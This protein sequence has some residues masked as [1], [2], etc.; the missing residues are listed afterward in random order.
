MSKLTG[1]TALVTGASRGIGRAIALR[2]ASEGARVGVHYASNEAAAKETVATIEAAGGTAFAV[3]TELGVPGDAE[4]LW[5]AF[6]AHADGLDILVN[7]AGIAGPGLIHEVSEADYDKVFA[8]NAKAPFFI[9]Q[10]GL[11][12]L[13]DGGRII[14]VSS[15]VTKVAFP[16]MAS[17]AASKGAVEVLT[18][19]LAQTL[20][21]RGITVNAVSP[22]TVETDIH[23]WMADPAAKAHAAGF[24]VF[25][26]VGLP[27]DVADVVSFL[28]SDDARWVTGQNIDVSG[29]SGLGV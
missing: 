23:P 28:A 12:R 2:L 15:G 24:S 5:R 9:V 4:A 14:N 1:T 16:G 10:K 26:R 3:R 11:E 13:R 21:S 20:G 17:Y 18:L 7:N 22:G 19:T 8:V 27:A 29:G 6:D 25:N